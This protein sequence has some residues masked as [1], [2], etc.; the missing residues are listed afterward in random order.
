MGRLSNVFVVAAESGITDTFVARFRKEGC[1]TMTSTV[2]AEASDWIA[3]SNPQ[4]AI[5]AVKDP[6]AANLIEALRK[7]RALPQPVPLLALG[8]SQLR[9]EVTAVGADFLPMPV[10]VRDVLT[11]AKMLAAMDTPGA[12]KMDKANIQGTLADYGLF[13]LVR[14]MIGLQRSGTVQVTRSNRHGEIW[15]SGGEVT[16]AQVGALQGSAALHHVLLWEDAALQVRLRPMVQRG[17]FRKR[18]EILLE[19][20]ERFVRD[21]IAA[22]KPL[23]RSRSIFVVDQKNKDADAQIPTEIMPV[24]RLLDGQRTLGDVIDDS[25]FRVFDTI[26]I[27]NR[28]LD[29]GSIRRWEAEASPA[30]TEARKQSDDWMDSPATAMVSHL[31]PQEEPMPFRPT[32][33]PQPSVLA[34]LGAATAVG[35][36]SSIEL[37]PSL[38]S[39]MAQPEP[40]P[41]PP[42]PAPVPA[43]VSFPVAVPPPVQQRPV[44]G[45]VVLLSPKIKPAP[46]AP[47]KPPPPR[48]RLSGEFNKLEADFFARESELYLD[49]KVDVFEDLDAGHKALR[50]PLR[51]SPRGK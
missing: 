49:E 35:M 24:I 5:F 20:A 9:D 32:P 7:A 6:Q 11:A 4:V 48:L 10:F 31:G 22:T 44:S 14:T 30:P 43:G 36:G 17:S 34:R 45:P 13:Y 3:R 16:S 18:T 12:T 39:D 50:P 8:P 27:I 46:A 15:F 26:R 19:E 2:F 40:A 25:P 1:E 28:L 38:M 37:D 23:G 47:P 33:L 21:Y 42:T 51:Q 29:L 41:R